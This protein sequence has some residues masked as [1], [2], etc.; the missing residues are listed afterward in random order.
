MTAAFP[1]SDQDRANDTSRGAGRCVDDPPRSL[2]SAR[3]LREGARL[4]SARS[5]AA[6]P[7]RPSRGEAAPAA[8]REQSDARAI[9]QRAAGRQARGL[10]VA[11][12]T[13]AAP[14]GGALAVGAGLPRSAPAGHGRAAG[15]SPIR[16][17]RRLHNRRRRG[18]ERARLAHLVDL[19]TPCRRQARHRS[20]L[21]PL[22]AR[23]ARH[24][25]GVHPGPGAC[26]RG[27]PHRLSRARA[28]AAA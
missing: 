25:P 21:S 10:R 5:R 14:L 8:V 23:P 7:M 17:E 1:E 12:A 18:S 16:R 13:W 22:S 2:S 15:I 28:R 9:D 27:L 6:P 26:A 4:K 20:A 11:L 24:R 3:C 19:R